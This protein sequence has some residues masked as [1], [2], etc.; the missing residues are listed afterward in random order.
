MVRAVHHRPYNAH[1]GRGLPVKSLTKQNC[2]EDE[3][4]IFQYLEQKRVK[5]AALKEA[6][7]KSNADDDDDGASVDDDEFDA[8]L[9]GLG[10]KSKDE[11]LDFMNDLGDELNE[12]AGGSK[13][14]QKKGKKADVD[15]DEAADDWD[16]D[17]N[18]DQD[19]I[20]T[21][22]GKKKPVSNDDV[23]EEFSSDED[24]SVSLDGEDDGNSG[25]S[26][27]FED[28]SA[29]DDEVYAEDDNESPPP[30][31]KLKPMTGKE[32]RQSLKHTN[33]KT[34]LKCLP[35]NGVIYFHSYRYEFIVCGCR[36][37]FGNA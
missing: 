15:D 21:K 25:D 27:I 36:R 16:D 7:R 37:F 9:D 5:Q 19:E 14:K 35:S 10:G 26:D 6:L 34:N 12:D 28:D 22:A 4:F 29:D 1:G 18:D 33:G 31:K 17:E 23:G 11:E 13:K 24:G 20:P 3:R 32:F 8:Y 30:A 2:T